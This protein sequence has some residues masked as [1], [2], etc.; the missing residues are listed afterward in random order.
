MF[1]DISYY[2]LIPAIGLISRVFANGPG[3]RGSIPRRVIPKP[4]KMLLDAAWLNT[5]HYI[6]GK[7]E[8]SKER[9]GTPLHLGVIAIEKGALGSPSTMVANFTFYLLFNTNNLL[10]DVTK[11]YDLILILY[12]QLYGLKWV[13]R[14]KNKNCFVWV[15]I[16]VGI[17]IK[18]I[19]LTLNESTTYR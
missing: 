9:S 4:Q 6:K 13:F 14:L 19:N 8:P 7:V 11:Y 15:S 1:P 17:S 18:N 3:D 16:R 12:T 2:Y 10:T 5:P